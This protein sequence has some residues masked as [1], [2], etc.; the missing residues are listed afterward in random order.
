VSIKLI[1]RR[2]FDGSNA[3]P[4]ASTTPIPP[5]PQSPPDL[6]PLR[7]VHYISSSYIA[8][9]EPC[10]RVRAAIIVMSRTCII[11]RSF[12]RRARLII[13]GRDFRVVASRVARARAHSPVLPRPR[14]RLCSLFEP[15]ATNTRSAEEIRMTT[16]RTRSGDPDHQTTLHSFLSFREGHFLS[17]LYNPFEVIF[18]QPFS[19]TGSHRGD[20]RCFPL[21]RIGATRVPYG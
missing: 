13:S 3:P 18:S 20:Q 10:V 1:S 14:G 16:T 11:R 8:R 21:T 12:L 6:A 4:L 19:P 17:L 9:N 2:I 5:T 15:S 7:S